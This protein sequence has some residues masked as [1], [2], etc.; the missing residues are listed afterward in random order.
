MLIIC[1]DISQNLHHTLSHF[2]SD[3]YKV[4]TNRS[5]LTESLTY[6]IN[7]TCYGSWYSS[8]SISFNVN[9]TIVRSTAL[10]TTDMLPSMTKERN[11]PTTYLTSNTATARGLTFPSTKDKATPT[12]RTP[13]NPTT[14]ALTTPS[15][16]VT[17][18]H[19]AQ[20]TTTLTAIVKPLSAVTGSTIS[21]SYSK[22]N[23]FD[24]EWNRVAMTTSIGIVVIVITAS[25]SVLGYRIYRRR[26]QGSR[27]I[28]L[29]N[30]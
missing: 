1:M 30:R 10:M 3:N 13:A 26:M 28:P 7:I 18:I 21:D 2:L 22:F 15:A 25:V 29:S 19:T 20:V 12:V 5:S 14:R 11:E 6:N 9:V 27:V 4:I 16:Q 24:D 17:V 8:G 23:F